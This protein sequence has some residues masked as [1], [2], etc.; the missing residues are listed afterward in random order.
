MGRSRSLKD[1]AGAE[2]PT[3]AEM[4]LL[5]TSASR[6]LSKVNVARTI[7]TTSSRTTEKM[8]VIFQTLVM[9]IF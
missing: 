2:R 5:R 6:M 1:G 7:V 3:A 9:C 4:A 8:A